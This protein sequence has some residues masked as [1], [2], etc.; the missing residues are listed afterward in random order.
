MSKGMTADQIDIAK[1]NV[2]LKGIRVQVKPLYDICDGGKQKGFGLNMKMP[3]KDKFSPSK[4]APFYFTD[5]VEAEKA[6]GL[7]NAWSVSK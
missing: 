7:I 6:A 2:A 5:E 1:L 3:G 4:F